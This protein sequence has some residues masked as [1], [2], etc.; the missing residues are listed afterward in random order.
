MAVNPY[1]TFLFIGRSTPAILGIN[2]LIPVKLEYADKHRRGHGQTL[3]F[4][5][6]IPRHSSCNSARA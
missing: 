1:S 6:V 5:R 2:L 4:L 3:A